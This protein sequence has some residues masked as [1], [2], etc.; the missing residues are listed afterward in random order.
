[1]SW[2]D[3]AQCL[4]IHLSGNLVYRAFHKMQT[5][6]FK[7]RLHNIT[8]FA[9]IN[10]NYD[11]KQQTLKHKHTQNGSKSTN[12]KSQTMTFWTH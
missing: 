6:K 11:H 5:L 3:F 4:L 10:H 1:M 12:H 8:F 7:S 9:A 2:L